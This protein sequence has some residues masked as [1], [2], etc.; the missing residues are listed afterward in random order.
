MSCRNCDTLLLL[1][2]TSSVSGWGMHLF[3]WSKISI[4]P[5]SI[6]ESRWVLGSSFGGANVLESKVFKMFCTWPKNW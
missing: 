5:L 2:K 1:K 4:L 3:Q 6:Y